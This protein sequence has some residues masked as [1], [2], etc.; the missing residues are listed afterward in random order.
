[1]IRLIIENLI[2]GKNSGRHQNCSEKWMK[3][4]LLIILSLTVH[5]QSNY[6]DN[7]GRADSD[8]KTLKARREFSSHVTAKFEESKKRHGLDHLSLNLDS[9]MVA[10]YGRGKTSAMRVIPQE[11]EQILALIS[12]SRSKPRQVYRRMVS[13]P[14]LRKYK[15]E[16]IAKAIKILSKTRSLRMSYWGYLSRSEDLPSYNLKRNELHYN[17]RWNEAKSFYKIYGTQ[18]MEA[19]IISGIIDEMNTKSWFDILREIDVFDLC[20]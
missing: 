12:Q 8:P 20:G 9:R 2:V 19:N 16:D 13:Y 4:F 6:G 3:F 17:A 15:R 18:E 14:R 5:A 1:M 7:R 10:Q 11:N